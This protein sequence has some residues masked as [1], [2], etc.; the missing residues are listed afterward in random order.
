M[1]NDYISPVLSLYPDPSLSIS[2]YFY[3]CICISIYLSVYLST[4]FVCIMSVPIYIQTISIYICIYMG[5]YLY[6]YISIFICLYLYS[7]LST[8]T[9]SQ[10]SLCKSSYTDIPG[11]PC[12]GLESRPCSL[13]SAK[14]R[15]R[16]IAASC[17]APLP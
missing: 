14:G 2:I 9:L 15:A 11:A 13:F 5:S 8:C 7:Y 6:P 10:V 4:I 16:P 12:P 1:W 3:I 17:S